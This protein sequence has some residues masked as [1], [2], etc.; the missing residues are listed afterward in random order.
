MPKTMKNTDMAATLKAYS[1]H[2][3]I[4]SQAEQQ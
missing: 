1:C 2:F 3:C 4:S